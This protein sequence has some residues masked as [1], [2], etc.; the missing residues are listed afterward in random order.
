VH[1]PPHSVAHSP[2]KVPPLHLFFSRRPSPPG[3]DQDE[4]QRRKIGERG[5]EYPTLSRAGHS[6]TNMRAIAHGTALQEGNIGRNCCAVIHDALQS[7][8]RRIAGASPSSTSWHT[9]SAR[10]PSSCPDARLMF[11]VGT[12]G[13]REHCPRIGSGKGKGC[14]HS[15]FPKG[16]QKPRV[17]GT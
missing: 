1:Q 8:G 14:S 4:S 3:V 10:I 5:Q 16:E 11:G 17:V 15:F 9:G 7:S 12:V 13:T 2:S 6:G